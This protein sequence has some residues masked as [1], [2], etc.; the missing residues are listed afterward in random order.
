LVSS[1]RRAELPGNLAIGLVGIEPRS[2]PQQGVA[3]I[4][5]QAKGW[6]AF[7]PIIGHQHGGKPSAEVLIGQK[8]VHL[9]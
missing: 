6:R 3:L 7:A 9:N 1:Q 8:L 2:R 5:L 4:E